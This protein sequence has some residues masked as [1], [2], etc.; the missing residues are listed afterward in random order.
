M[1]PVTSTSTSS[2]FVSK[3]YL[4]HINGHLHDRLT[5]FKALLS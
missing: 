5:G 1:H 2:D 3:N 4:E